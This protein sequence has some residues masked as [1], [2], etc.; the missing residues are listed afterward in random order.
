M[1]MTDKLTKAILAPPL[2]MVWVVEAALA[3]GVIVLALALRKRPGQGE[4]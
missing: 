1:I 2:W 3:G 4:K